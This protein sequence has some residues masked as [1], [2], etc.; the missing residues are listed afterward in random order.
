MPELRRDITTGQWVIVASKRA[1]RP[2][3]VLPGG[4]RGPTP[5]SSPDTCPFCPGNEEQTPPPIRVVTVDDPSGAQ[6]AASVR[7]ARAGRVSPQASSAD[8]LVTGKRETAQPDG[9]R[10]PGPRGGDRKGTDRTP[11]G[12][13]LLPTDP[14]PRHPTWLLRVCPNRFPA[15]EVD[16][17]PGAPGAPPFFERAPAH[18][19]HEVI[20]ET[21]EHDMDLSRL[22][23]QALE[24]VVAAYAE[25]D[26][27]LRRKPQI[28]HVLI[29]RNHGRMAGASLDH[30][31][32]QVAAMPDVPPA[33]ALRYETARRYFD[34]AGRS[35][36]ADLVERELAAADRIVEAGDGLAVL[37]PFASRLPFETWIV[38]IAPSAAAISAERDGCLARLARLLGRT[39]ERIDRAA[40]DPPYNLILYSAPAG[41]ER[42]LWF[43]W[44]VQIVPRV[45]T[46]AGFEL[47]TGT[48][49]NIVRPEEAAAFLREAIS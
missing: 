36:Y 8:G 9:K 30:P 48:S 20:I 41:E 24:R 49:I 43:S 4:T 15:L 10:R 28:A 1:R 38:P 29:F 27:D 18:G 25:R 19:L 40:G 17:E 35:L 32:S 21:P 26:H 37:C 34:E 46:P 31:H 11:S 23:V 12:P 2:H 39:L 33:A 3:D 16:E 6:T 7:T 5:A 47:G 22:D 14:R 42:A 13:D 45:T 44:H